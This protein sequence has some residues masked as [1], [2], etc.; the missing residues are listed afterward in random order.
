MLDKLSI[1]LDTSEIVC[2]GADVLKTLKFIMTILNII[3]IGV[4]IILILFISI[5]FAKNVIASSADEMNKNV[6]RAVKRLI[7][8]LILFLIPTI[9]N[10][11]IKVLGS[12]GVD[13]AN[14]ITIA[15][16]ETDFSKYKVDYSDEE[17]DDKEIE[18]RDTRTSKM[19]GDNS[20]DTGSNNGT[21][22]NGASNN[23]TSNSG[24][25]EEQNNTNQTP[26]STKEQKVYIGDS[27]IS[28]TRD[29]L[30]TSA[31]GREW[32]TGNL[33]SILTSETTVNKINDASK[34]D[35]CKIIIAAYV[36]SISSTKDAQNIS[37][38]IST[39]K[40]K[41]VDSS[42][43][44]FIVASIPPVD[45]RSTKYKNYTIKEINNKLRSNAGGKYTYC[46]INGT[47]TNECQKKCSKKNLSLDRCISSCFIN[48]INFT[49]SYYKT[50]Y[51]Y[52][53]KC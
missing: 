47:I 24:G 48:G 1:I 11:S 19:P 20:N 14:C 53:D 40:R 6:Q 16:N 18:D 39:L 28:S 26:T 23:G 37:D 33:T 31:G 43:C 22:N 27:L 25:N 52:L 15:K 10:A 2:G 21:S 29:V 41:L 35:N 8:C 5:D 50:Y 4:P 49:E 45:A 32:I 38:T 42:K 36:T 17:Y 3:F 9:V 30:G 13:Y 44:K 46:N 34:N 12:L 51:T 7:A